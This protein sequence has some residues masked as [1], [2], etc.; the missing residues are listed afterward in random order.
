M[1]D[2]RDSSYDG[3][4]ESGTLRSGL[5]ILT[6][7][8][9]GSVDFIRNH[10]GKKELFDILQL[11]PLEKLVSAKYVCGNISSN[12]YNLHKF[13]NVNKLLAISWKNLSTC[14]FLTYI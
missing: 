6:D 10:K 3:Q 4:D 13:A 5:G 7:M 12:S 8:F 1:L 11:S 2:F 9:Y 14:E